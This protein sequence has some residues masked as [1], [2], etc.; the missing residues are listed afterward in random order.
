[1]KN[2]SC[3]TNSK[4][5]KKTYACHYCLQVFLNETEFIEH[6]EECSIHKPIKVRFNSGNGMIKF[7]NYDRQF[8]IRLLYSVKAWVFYTFPQIAIRQCKC[9]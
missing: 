1:M 9:S 4:H 5:N 3:F 7:K 6:E 2:S 8:Y